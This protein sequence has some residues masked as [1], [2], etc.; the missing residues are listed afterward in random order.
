M[1]LIDNSLLIYTEVSHAEMSQDIQVIRRVF[2]AMEIPLGVHSHNSFM[3]SLSSVL[4][5]SVGLHRVLVYM[6]QNHYVLFDLGA[7]SAICYNY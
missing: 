4:R 7:L 3:N 1:L 2:K 6:L 5:I